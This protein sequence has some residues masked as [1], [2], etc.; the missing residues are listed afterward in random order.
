MKKLINNFDVSI[1][2]YRENKNDNGVG[3]GTYALSYYVPSSSSY[4]Y[5]ESK[6]VCDTRITIEK[7]ENQKFYVD[8]TKKENVKYTL[9]Q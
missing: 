7:Y 5:V 6:S 9:M 8:A 4:S 2:V 3:L 1:K